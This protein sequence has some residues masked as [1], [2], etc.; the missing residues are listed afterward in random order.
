VQH[1]DGALLRGQATE[2]T[3]EEVPVADAEQLVGGRRSV[4]RQHPQVRG[5]TTL[6]R[7]LGDADIDQETL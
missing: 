1:E 6:A 2:A 7:R 5:P 3:F 4:D